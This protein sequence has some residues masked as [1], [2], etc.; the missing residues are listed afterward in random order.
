MTENLE[1]WSLPD[2]HAALRGLADPDDT[3]ALMDADS[4]T[5][6]CDDALPEPL[7]AARTEATD[8]D[9]AHLTALLARTARQDEDALAELY[10]LTSNRV[11]GLALRILRNPAAA[12][13]ICGDVFFQ[14]WRQA[15]RFDPARGRPLAWILTIARSRALDFLRR[16]EPAQA[17]PEP[18]SLLGAEPSDG[19]N[20]QDLLLACRDSTRLHAALANLEAQPRQLIALVFFRGLTHEEAASHSGLPLGTVKSHVRRALLALRKT[21]AGDLDRSIA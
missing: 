14:V 8:A 15:L 2:A 5:P 12:E 18:H 3:E 11:Y 9:V 21:L 1:P 6:A 13:E 7:C 4:D 10:D 16:Q 20:P 19:Q 17:H